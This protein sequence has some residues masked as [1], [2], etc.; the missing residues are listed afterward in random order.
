M[1]VFLLCFSILIGF[2]VRYIEKR[3]QYLRRYIIKYKEI[4]S[5]NESFKNEINAIKAHIN[6][7]PELLITLDKL[8]SIM[9]Q[10]ILGMRKKIPSIDNIGFV[11]HKNEDDI[12]LIFI[13]IQVLLY[14]LSIGFI[15]WFLILKI[16]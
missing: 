16:Y 6:D 13:R 12:L 10:G 1:G 15:T 8:K 2:S 11:F 14:S 4:N 5:V 9:D 7:S 3:K